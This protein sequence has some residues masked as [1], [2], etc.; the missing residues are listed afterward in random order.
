MTATRV[1]ALV[2]YLVFALWFGALETV[3]HGVL[4]A[5]TPSLSLVF[6]LAVLARCEEVDLW[7]LVPAT[8]LA[9]A[10]Y[11]ADAPSVL[12]GGTA[13]VMWTALAS[14]SVLEAGGF[15]GRALV[16]LVCV[17]LGSA[18]SSAAEA[19]RDGAAGDAAFG[20]LALAAGAGLSSA[21]VAAIAGGAL[22]SL[23]GLSALRRRAW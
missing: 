11:S 9:R 13:L 3:V 18:W 12:I 15:V 20:G 8:V 4:G 17:F 19:L 10:P 23:P 2:L 5:W 7:W 21:V 1:L 22:Q 14:R 16:A 6:A